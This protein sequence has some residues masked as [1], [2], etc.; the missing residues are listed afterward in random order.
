MCV[1]VCVCGDFM[2]RNMCSATGGCGFRGQQPW[3]LVL[4]FNFV[5]DRT[6][7][8]FVVVVVTPM[9][10]TSWPTVFHDSPVS[11]RSPGITDAHVG[12]QVLCGL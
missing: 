5:W 6:S 9:N 3:V 2:H 12:A 4:T 8:F 11:H 7:F 10:Q 1:S